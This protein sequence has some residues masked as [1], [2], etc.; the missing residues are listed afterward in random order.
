MKVDVLR[1]PRDEPW[2]ARTFDLLDPSG[3]T[4]F[5]IAPSGAV[6]LPQAVPEIPVRS[7]SEAAQYYTRVLGFELDWGDDEGGIGGVS[8]GDCRLFLTNLPFRA[9]HGPQAPVISWLNLNSRSEVD[10]LFER[11]LQAGAR[12][13]ESVQDKP[14][15]LREFRV[16]DPDG[17]QLRVFYDFSSD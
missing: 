1:P 11:W 4:I 15:K 13:V 10:E 6:R 9:V 5:V 14:W 2:G 8:H 7:V 16:A 3:N 17:N 12:V